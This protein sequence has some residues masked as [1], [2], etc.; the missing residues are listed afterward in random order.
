M[1]DYSYATIDAIN[2]YNA[3]K[4]DVIIIASNVKF[5]KPIRLIMR[6]TNNLITKTIAAPSTTPNNLIANTADA[7]TIFALI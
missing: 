6:F 3:M 2:I 4:L 1:G 7:N 5:K